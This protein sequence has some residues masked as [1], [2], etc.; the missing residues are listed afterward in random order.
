M[1]TQVKEKQDELF[2]AEDRVEAVEVEIETPEESAAETV[3]EPEPEP[4]QPS[5]EEHKSKVSDTK[6]RIDQLTKK[7]REAERREEEAIR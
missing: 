2:E 5:D 6:R 3:A 7:M 1:S 4:E